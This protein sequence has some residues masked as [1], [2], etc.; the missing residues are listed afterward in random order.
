MQTVNLK[1]R[2]RGSV[3]SEREKEIRDSW[4]KGRQAEAQRLRDE[5]LRKETS[6][7]TFGPEEEEKEGCKKQATAL[8]LVGL[9]MTFLSAYGVKLL[10][11]H[12]VG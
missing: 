3:S 9:S 6:P 4:G 5:G 10:I 1:T 2:D 7:G 8:L 12:I 11:N